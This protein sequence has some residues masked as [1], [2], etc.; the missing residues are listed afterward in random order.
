MPVGS[1]SGNGPGRIDTCVQLLAQP[2]DSL[3]LA[4]YGRVREIYRVGDCL[5]PR[6]IGAAV[7]DGYQVG[8]RI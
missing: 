7:R 1:A 5:A 3:Y 2:E 8:K 6:G 4:L